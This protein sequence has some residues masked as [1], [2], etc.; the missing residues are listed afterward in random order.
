[1]REL[2]V[3][4]LVAFGL[5]FLGLSL[6][7]LVIGVDGFVTPLVVTEAPTLRRHL[8]EGSPLA[9]LMAI[10]GISLSLGFLAFCL[11]TWRARVLPYWPAA[12][13]FPGALILGVTTSEP[14]WLES[15]GATNL[16]GVLFGLGLAWFGYAL[17]TGRRR[18]ATT[19][20]PGA[21]AAPATPD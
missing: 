12:L 20:R 6:L 1:V 15:R 14:L 16:G 19:Q 9:T 4:G 8:F 21:A 2:G 17:W 11:A 3:S 13:T 10:Q 18:L 7:I 5:S